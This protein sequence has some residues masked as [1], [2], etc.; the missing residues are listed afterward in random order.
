MYAYLTPVL[1]R[2]RQLPYSMYV[3]FGIDQT[4]IGFYIA[5]LYQL[6]NVVYAGGINIAVNMYLFDAFVSVNFF[7][8]LLSSRARRLGYDSGYNEWYTKTPN[9]KQSFYREV[10]YLIELHLKIVR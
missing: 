1:A 9:F 6:G 8:S 7:L 3:P 2:Q 5:Y 4:E 10:C